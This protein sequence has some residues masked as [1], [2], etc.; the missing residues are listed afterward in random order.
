[1]R[2]SPSLL[3]PSAPS[4]LRQTLSLSLCPGKSLYDMV[5]KESIG[6]LREALTSAELVPFPRSMP[7]TAM[8]RTVPR[9]LPG[10]AMPRT[11]PCPERHQC[12][13]LSPCPRLFQCPQVDRS[14]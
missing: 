2:A 5:V 9:S 8:P 4:P 12:P 3:L 13:R 11:V 1:M 7:G 10:T 14:P 6:V